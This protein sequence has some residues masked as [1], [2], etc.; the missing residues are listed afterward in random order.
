MLGSNF[1][2]LLVLDKTLTCDENVASEKVKE[3]RSESCQTCVSESEETV[4][5]EKDSEVDHGNSI[6]GIIKQRRSQKF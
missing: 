1:C 6:A 3:T 2:G 4:S 5:D